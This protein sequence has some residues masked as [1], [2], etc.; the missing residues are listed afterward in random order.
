MKTHKYL[1]LVKDPEGK[2]RRLLLWADVPVQNFKRGNWN[3][4][5]RALR[6]TNK[7]RIDKLTW[8]RI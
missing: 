4:E 5:V 8:T 2:Y 3:I 1:V 6:R 7:I